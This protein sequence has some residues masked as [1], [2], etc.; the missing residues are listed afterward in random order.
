V[1]GITLD[2]RELEEI[3]P[4][5]V[6][7]IA[8]RSSLCKRRGFDFEVIAG[9]EEINAAFERAGVGSLL[10]LDDGMAHALPA[11]PS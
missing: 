1:S 8:F 11:R 5:G 9:S 2:L 3:D 4:T 10:G 6:A 7:V